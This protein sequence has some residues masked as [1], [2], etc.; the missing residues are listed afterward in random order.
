MSFP[1]RQRK[2]VLALSAALGVPAAWAPA[3][4][5]QNAS[6]NASV[7]QIPSVTVTGTSVAKPDDTPPVYAGGQVARGARLGMLGN[8]DMM[9]TPFS[10]TSYTSELIQNQQATSLADVLD[11]DPGVTAAGPWFFDN[12]NIRGFQVQ[13]SEI[14]FNGLYGIANSEGVQLEGIDRVEILKGPSTL[15][16]G[17]SPRGTS[18]GAINLVPKRADDTPLT[19]LSTG[20]VSDGNLGANVDIGRRFGQD[21]AFGIRLNAS[22]R[23]GDTSVDHEKVR[24]SNV[25]LGLDYRVERFRASADVGASN[26]K[27][28]GAKNNYFVNTP[29]LPRAPEGDVNPYPAWSYQ[30]KDYVFGMVRAEYDITSNWSIGGAYGAS[31]TKRQTNTPWGVVANQAGDLD[32]FSSAL[33]EKTRSRSGEINTRLNFTTGPIK[34]ATVL[35]I[36]DYNTKIA[37]YQPQSSWSGQ[38]NIY[39]PTDLSAP[40]DLR[41]D[42]DRVPQSDTHL[43]SYAITDTLSMMD[44]RVLLTLGLRHQKIDV[45]SY[46]WDTGAWQSNYNRSKNTP[47][48]GFLVKPVDKLSLYANY[49]EALSQG[50]MAPSTANNPGEV[51]AP[52]VSKQWEL[53]AKVDWGTFTTTLSTYEIKRPSGFLDADNFYRLAGEQRNRGVELSMFGEA[54]R[55]LRV[56]GG[57]AWTRAVLT[58][59]PGGQ[60]DGARAYGIPTWSVKLGAEYDIQQVPGLTAIARMIYNSSMP[61]DAANTETIPSWTRFDVGARYATKIASHPVVFRA[62]VENVFNRR[63]WDSSPAYQMVTSAAPRT[64]MLSASIDF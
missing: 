23:D 20:F 57:V 7:Q 28:S 46:V 6:G 59:T 50:A 58:D 56:L 44:E 22:H 53:G 63:Y 3:A 42:G 64:Y 17:G 26:Q 1:L 32:F 19:R 54:A 29:W 55:G 14:G 15:L 31:E 5:A 11:N 21:N 27:I 37:G 38:S 24:A 4:L 43:R 41:F 35:A 18:G 40:T 33:D 48:V 45:N 10:V 16:N 9:S 47:A 13:R 61:Y 8:V 62:T 49:V 30:D 60:F 51:F 2:L 36:T 52:F 12:F 34:H 25:T 39:D